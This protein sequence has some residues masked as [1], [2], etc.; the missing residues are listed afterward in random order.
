VSAAK[1]S[2]VKSTVDP[3]LTGAVENKNTGDIVLR[4]GKFLVAR[5]NLT[6]GF[7]RKSVVF[8]Y[9]DGPTGTA[10]VAISKP[11]NYTLRDVDPTK[12]VDYA[13][14]DPIIY[15]GGPVNK[16]A[17]MM[18]HTTDFAS[19]NTIYTNSDLCISSD[20]VM[21]DKLYSGNWPKQFRL[22]AGA[23]V[24]APGQLDFEMERNL[25]LLGDLDMEK[26]F[27]YDQ[28]ELWGWSIEEIGRQVIAKYF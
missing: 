8:L 27:D 5:P 11:T 20:A 2:K 18:L 28:E 15:S 25:W 12:T 3:Y 10:G 26:I 4:T 6:S 23:C 9:E 21:V 19:S 13:A 22:T 16:K 14:A 1:K 24:W 17:V 7:F